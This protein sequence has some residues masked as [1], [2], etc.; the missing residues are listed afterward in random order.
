VNRRAFSFDGRHRPSPLHFVVVFGFGAALTAALALLAGA[1]SRVAVA[2]ASAA[3]HVTAIALAPVTFA[4]RRVA[5]RLAQAALIA[6]ALVARIPATVA[7]ITLIS[8]VTLVSLISLIR[9]VF[10]LM[11]GQSTNRTPFQS[12]THVP[13]RSPREPDAPPGDVGSALP[14]GAASF[15]HYARHE[16]YARR[17]RA[18]ARPVPTLLLSMT[19]QILRRAPR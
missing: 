13:L 3:V 2:G 11:G 18:L 17:G 9:H 8:L 12:A 7:L 5:I 4:T 14:T 10:H 6:V 19:W 1:R 16:E 15:H